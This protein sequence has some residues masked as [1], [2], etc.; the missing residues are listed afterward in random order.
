MF[1]IRFLS[2]MHILRSLESDQ[3][4]C[5]AW[6]VLTQLDLNITTKMGESS[7]MV[8]RYPYLCPS[9]SK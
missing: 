6:L 9:V 4:V 2:E 3:N 7:Y 5:T 8:F 1:E